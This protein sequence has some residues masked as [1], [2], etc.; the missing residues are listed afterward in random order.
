M[1][2]NNIKFIRQGDVNLHPISKEEFEAFQGKQIEHENI[3]TVARGEA[4]GST[5]DLHCADM[6][7][8]ED[9]EERVIAFLKEARLTHTSDHLP[10]E[11]TPG[12]YRQVPEREVDHFSSTT[13]KV[14]D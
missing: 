5:H 8:K 11:I 2:L 4:T 12:Y 13:R 1:L 9:G 7:I 6:I 14:V 10:L 3:Y